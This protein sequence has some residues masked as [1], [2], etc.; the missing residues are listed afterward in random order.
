MEEQLLHKYWREDIIQNFEDNKENEALPK[1]QRKI[2]KA[3]LSKFPENSTTT[4]NKNN[5]WQNVQGVQPTPW[6]GTYLIYLPSG[7]VH[8]ACHNRAHTDIIQYTTPKEYNSL[9]YP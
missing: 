1:E 8:L 9:F 4:E 2:Y 6:L 7:S 3:H 5:R